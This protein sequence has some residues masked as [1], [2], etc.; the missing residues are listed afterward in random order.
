MLSISQ[1]RIVSIDG[2]MV[3]CLKGIKSGI[4]LSLT[5]NDRIVGVIGLTGE[6]SDI[7]QFNKLV[8]RTAKNDDGA[9]PIITRSFSN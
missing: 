3:K 1:K 2:T 8:C 4:N 5:L 7:R 9:N 6:P